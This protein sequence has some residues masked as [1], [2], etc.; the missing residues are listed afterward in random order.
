MA[1]L[2]SPLE[3]ESKV[4]ASAAQH[5]TASAHESASWASQF[6]AQL[7]A[8]VPYA[9]AFTAVSQAT[10][11]ALCDATDLELFHC[12]GSAGPAF[13][14]S[15]DKAWQHLRLLAQAAAE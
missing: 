1:P 5:I 2:W 3:P 6:L 15:R 8:A 12:G 13:Y 14:Y 9:D 4:L 10:K 7:K 11:C